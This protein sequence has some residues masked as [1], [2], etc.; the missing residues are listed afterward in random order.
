MAK[1]VAFTKEKVFP[2]EGFLGVYVCPDGD[3]NL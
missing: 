1:I 2:I 3:T